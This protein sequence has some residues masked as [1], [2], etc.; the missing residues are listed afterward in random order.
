MLK[1]KIGFQVGYGNASYFSAVCK[2]S[3]GMNFTE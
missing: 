1:E 3:T 2:K